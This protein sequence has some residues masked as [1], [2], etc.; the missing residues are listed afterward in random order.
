M[1]LSIKI[2][3]NA[4]LVDWPLRIFSYRTFSQ[5]GVSKEVEK[6]SIPM[7][8]MVITA[9]VDCDAF[10]SMTLPITL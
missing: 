9:R 7:S 2:E 5:Y 1:V 3:F 8:T 10:A 6:G 4:Y